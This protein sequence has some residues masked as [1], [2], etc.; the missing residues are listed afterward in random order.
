MLWSFLE[1]ESQA[2]EPRFVLSKIHRSLI[3][4]E[5]RRPYGVKYRTLAMARYGFMK[6][7]IVIEWQIIWTVPCGCESLS[8]V[9]RGKRDFC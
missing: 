9:N 8:Y 3:L 7:V 6:Q 2:E 4:S 5:M 1:R